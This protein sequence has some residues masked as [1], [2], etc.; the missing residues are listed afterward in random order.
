MLFSHWVCNG[1]SREHLYSMS[2]WF[3]I[4]FFIYFLNRVQYAPV[5]ITIPTE[6]AVSMWPKGIVFYILLVQ[7]IHGGVPSRIQHWVT[8]FHVKYINCIT[9]CGILMLYVESTVSI[10]IICITRKPKIWQKM[11]RNAKLHTDNLLI[12]TFI[13]DPT[14][15][16]ISQQ[17]HRV[18]FIFYLWYEKKTCSC[19]QF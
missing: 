9:D 19:P 10:I 12:K 18:F 6:N 8:L 7:N 5:T 15:P 13:V 1:Q 4:A 3:L 11:T 2:A 17:C 14:P 16:N